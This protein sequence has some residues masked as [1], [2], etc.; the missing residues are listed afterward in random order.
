MY[1]RYERKLTKNDLNLFRRDCPNSLSIWNEFKKW[2]GGY[3]LILLIVWPVAIYQTSF[4]W[5]TSC[6]LAIAVVK[7]NP[8]SL[9]E[10]R[11][12]LLHK[13][14]QFKNE[15]E[16]YSSLKINRSFI[17]ERVESNRVLE[18]FHDEGQFYIYET[19]EQE[20]YATDTC[21][22]NDLWPNDLFELIQTDIEAERLPPVC[23]GNKI[24]P[25]KTIE[26]RQLDLSKVPENIHGLFKGNMEELIHKN[27][28][29]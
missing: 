7:L 25:I 16:K 6:L 3:L 29:V 15:N 18:V 1:S 14:A 2:Y 12:S 23:F 9:R 4:I 5:A 28:I 24:T 10:F 27:E 22:E 26:F 17:V 11:N 21:G 20:L 13:K 19:D 8:W